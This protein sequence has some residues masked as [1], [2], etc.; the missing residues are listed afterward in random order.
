MK[1][2]K[3][4]G[5][6]YITPIHWSEIYN[7]KSESN[8]RN[9]SPESL[10]SFLKSKWVLLQFWFERARQRR[11]LSMMDGH[12]LKDIGISRYDAVREADKW[13]WQT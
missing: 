8:L 12:L 11:E 7:K 3:L 6:L 5:K 10:L 4:S 2:D 9:A 1:L 13:F